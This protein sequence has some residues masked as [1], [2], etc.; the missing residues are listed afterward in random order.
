MGEACCPEGRDETHQA[1]DLYAQL[2][3]FSRVSFVTLRGIDTMPF[4]GEAVAE[5]GT[6]R[7]EVNSDLGLSVCR[8]RGPS[9]WPFPWPAPHSEVR[10][11]DLEFRLRRGWLA[12]EPL[13]V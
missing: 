12:E 11:V 10:C 7:A 9:P 6:D 3:Y 5:K 4:T 1:R 8:A 2:T 13:W